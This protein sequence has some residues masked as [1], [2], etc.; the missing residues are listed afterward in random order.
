MPQLSG[1]EE[2][3]TDGRSEDVRKKD[4]CDNLTIRTHLS[5]EKAKLRATTIYIRDLRV[6]RSNEGIYQCQRDEGRKE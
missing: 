1:S 2:A 5:R 4:R 6:L 3:L